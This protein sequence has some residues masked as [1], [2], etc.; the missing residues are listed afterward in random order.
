MSDTLPTV[1]A[2]SRPHRI[3][4]GKTA[5]EYGIRE[6]PDA[7]F[8]R[9][10]SPEKRAEWLEAWLVMPYKQ[11]CEKVGVSEM[12][13]VRWRKQ[14]KG[15]AEAYEDARTARAA[16]LADSTI[17]LADEAVEQADALRKAEL[18]IRSRQWVA[19]RT[20]RDYAERQAREESHEVRVTIQLEEHPAPRIARVLTEAVEVDALIEPDSEPDHDTAGDETGLITE[21]QEG[22]EGC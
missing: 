13:P 22:G 9:A 5:Q 11:A 8:S 18:R 7:F 17:S 12:A 21:G 1:P 14:D 3:G 10:Y 15:F 19:G 20:S 2:Q 16:S 6:R 4:E